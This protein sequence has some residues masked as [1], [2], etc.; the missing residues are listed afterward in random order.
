MNSG[1]LYYCCGSC[2]LP[3]SARGLSRPCGNTATQHRRAIQPQPLLQTLTVPFR[4]PQPSPLSFRGVV[5]KPSSS[6]T[7][8]GSDP[9]VD[10]SDNPCT[11]GSGRGKNRFNSQG[12]GASAGGGSGSG[13]CASSNGGGASGG[14]SGVSFVL[15]N[16]RHAARANRRRLTDEQ[17]GFGRWVLLVRLRLLLCICW[18]L[19]VLVLLYAGATKRD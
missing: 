14:S 6:N 4:T 9:S 7:N 13:R 2:H 12:G 8:T 5:R 10:G 19:H 3:P 15:K 17:V 16:K 1:L 18:S 11:K